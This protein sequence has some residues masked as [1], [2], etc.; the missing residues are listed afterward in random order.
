MAEKKVAK[1]KTVK[2]TVKK[3]VAIKKEVVK[4]NGRPSLYTEELADAIC[5]A[6]SKDTR[7][8]KDIMAAYETFPDADTVNEWRYIYPEFNTKYRLAQAHQAELRIEEAH[9]ISEDTSRDM[10]MNKDGV[11]VPNAVAVARDRL[12]IDTR[13]YMASKLAAAI[14]GEKIQNEITVIK[15]EDT[16]EALK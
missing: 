15:H 9:R 10:Y 14:Y 6:I 1:K 13:K 8:L 3:E 2:K 11:E 4:K 5:R 12:R 7:G 16:I